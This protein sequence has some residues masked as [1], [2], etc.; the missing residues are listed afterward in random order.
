LLAGRDPEEA[1][2]LLDPVLELM[3]DAVHGDE[4]T[5]TRITGDG[6]VALFGAPR[7]HEDHALRACRA[8]LRMQEDVRHYAHAVEAAS[9]QPVSIRVGLSSGE[10]VVRPAGDDPHA[11]YVGPTS[12]LA[13]RME[14]LATPGSVL[15]TADT[16]RLVDGFVQARPVGDLPVADSGR[17]V[18]AFELTGLVS[19]RGRL[20]V[21]TARGLTP[22]VGRA[23]PLAALRAA[24]ARAGAGQGQVAR[25][26][27]RSS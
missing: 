24:L 7:A 10:V 13:A 11:D 12:Y 2:R 18:S 8:A 5:V 9:D 20:E 16:F 17:A 4:G 3:M 21:A 23:A 1:E 27:S 25:P 15:I 26:G 14:Q 6:I 19:G 22:L